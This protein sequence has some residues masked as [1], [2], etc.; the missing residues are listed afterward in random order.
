MLTSYYQ[1]ALDN[2][3]SNISNNDRALTST[4]RSM[5]SSVYKNP[6]PSSAIISTSSSRM[7]TNYEISDEISRARVQ[8]SLQ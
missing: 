6:T 5:N 4:N 1:K 7:F 3:G 8:V 2:T